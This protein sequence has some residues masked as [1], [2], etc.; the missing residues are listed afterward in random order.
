MSPSG[1]P[2]AKKCDTSN[3]KAMI[4]RLSAG[5]D[6]ERTSV[7]LPVEE[8]DVVEELMEEYL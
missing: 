5:E 8:R 6:G 3:W 4:S 2:K 1:E 7:V